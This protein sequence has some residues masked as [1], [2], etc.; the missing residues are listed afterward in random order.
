ML[1]RTVLRSSAAIWLAPFLVAFVVLLLSDDLTAGVTPR[2]WPSALGSASFALPFVAPACATAGAW[3]GARCTR[4]AVAHWAPARSWTGVAL[5]LL[6][7]VLALGALGMAVALAVPVSAGHLGAVVPPP[8]TVLGVVLIWLSLLAAHSFAGF[9]LGRRLPRVLSVPLAL[10]GSFAVMAYP[11]AMEPLWLRH[12]V[13]GGMTSCCSLDRALNWRAAASAL[14]LALGVIAAAVAALTVLA[15]RTRTVLVCTAVAVGLAG[16]GGL[17]YGLPADPV[18]ARRTDVLVCAG[19]APKIC[20]WPE[21]GPPAMIR[22]H[23]ADALHRLRQAGLTVPTAL[24]MAAG[25]DTSPN[26]DHD[27]NAS[28]GPAFI[29]LW[30]N[31]TP[32]EVR[33]GV[34]AALLPA[35]PA[36]CADSRRSSGTEDTYAPTVVW[37]A[38]TAGTDP[39][40]MAGRYGPEANAVAARVLRAPRSEQL[41]WFTRNYRALTD[42]TTRPAPVPAPRGQEEAAR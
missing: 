25:S 4:G 14:V 33:A 1:W 8:G 35:D 21:A 30:R 11:A 9:L 36:A 13:A 2:Y 23:A 18:T 24:T 22:E 7:P 10:L 17:A 20:L 19:D 27:P 42:C 3:E 32:S 15:R 37:L 40:L 26:P 34:G 29:G 41:A 12:M 39:R 5:P 16:S 38:L 28:H 6:V 31:P